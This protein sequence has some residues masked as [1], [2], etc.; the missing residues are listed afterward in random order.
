MTEKMETLLAESKKMNRREFIQRAAVLG[1]GMT[2]AA[3]MWSSSAKAA[4]P[5]KGRRFRMGLGGGATTDSLDPATMN[6]NYMLNVTWQLRNNLVEIDHNFQPQPELAE[7]WDVSPDAATWIFKLRRGVEFH[8]GKTLDAEDIIYNINH[9]RSKDSKSAAKALLAP[10]REIKPD[11]KYNVIFKL[12]AGN[13]DFPFIL[14]DYHLS[15]FPAGTKG[16]EFE[17]GIG[18]GGYILENFEPGVRTIAKRNPNYWKK[19]RAHFDEVETLCINDE[20]SRTNALQTGAVDHI[21]RAPL[22]TIHL[23]QQTA[24]IRVIKCNGPFHF[25][26]PMHTDIPPYDNND[27]RL[28]LKYALDREQI[29]KIILRGFG[30]VGNDHPI[31]PVQRFHASDLPQR[32]YDPDKAKYYLKKAGMQNHT[33]K[34]HTSD[35]T[36][37]LDTAVLYKEQAAKA[38]INIELVREPVDGYWTNVWLKKPFVSCRWGGRPTADWMFSTGYAKDAQW[39]DSHWKHKRF[40]DLLLNARAEVDASKRREMYFEMQKICRDEGGVIVFMFKDFVEAV[41]S[42]VKFDALAGNWASDGS[43]NAERW[44]FES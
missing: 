14:S 10:I 28:A 30:T 23:L 18:T 13:A 22:K 19:G 38:G 43:R 25:S 8:D 16:A 35:E 40:N 31:A 42:N 3:S 1:I 41:R 2:T 37:F 29:V 15:I 5:Q 4:T 21:N 44:W 32:K 36:G 17:K 7:S 27:V 39:N 11:G 6:D 33:F 24:G 34:L 26:M 20:T 9:H 12:E